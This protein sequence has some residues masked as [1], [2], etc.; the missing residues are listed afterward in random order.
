MAQVKLGFRDLDDGILPDVCIRCAPATVR[1]AKSCSRG[2]ILP[3]NL[4]II[5]GPVLGLLIYI[6]AVLSNVLA[7][8]RRVEAMFCNG[9]FRNQVVLAP[10]RLLE[11][12]SLVAA[13]SPS[14]R[15]SFSPT[16]KDTAAAILGARPPLIGTACCWR[17]G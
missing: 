17:P 7:K 10:P 12:S 1:K 3:S 16:Y 11:A 15:F 5:W 14:R 8:R 9:A 6:I 13:W 4:C 2:I